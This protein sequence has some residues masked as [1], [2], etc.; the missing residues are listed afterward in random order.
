MKKL[1]W[2]S[3]HRKIQL[4]QKPRCEQRT[5]LSATSV[6]SHP[7]PPP[8]APPGRRV[9]PCYFTV[10]APSSLG[11]T[12]WLPHWTRPSKFLTF[13]KLVDSDVQFSTLKSNALWG[14]FSF[15]PPTCLLTWFPVWREDCPLHQVIKV[16]CASTLGE[17]EYV[18]TDKGFSISGKLSEKHLTYHLVLLRLLPWVLIPGILFWGSSEGLRHC[19]VTALVNSEKAIIS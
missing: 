11:H 17:Q 19:I 12:R 1:A 15:L 3:S 4:R 7:S 2:G 14:W 5:A 6:P 8:A 9:L 10:R 16:S 18:C 13:C